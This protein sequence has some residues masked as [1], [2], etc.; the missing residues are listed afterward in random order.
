LPS[1]TRQPGR[2]FHARRL[3]AWSIFVEHAG[4]LQPCHSHGPWRVLRDAGHA[5]WDEGRSAG[6]TRMALTW[7]TGM[8]WFWAAVDLLGLGIPGLQ[9]LE[10]VLGDRVVL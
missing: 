5:E 8:Q 10:A 6:G 9:L 7:D 1:G 4:G 2:P 3:V